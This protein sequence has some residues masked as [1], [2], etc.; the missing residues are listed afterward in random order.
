MTEKVEQLSEEL[1]SFDPTERREALEVLAEMAQQHRIQLP[2][3][4]GA[5]NLHCH[6]FF[7]YNA[8]GYS[9][10]AFAWE[11][12][13]RGLEV[14][15]IVD[16]DCLDG[17]REFLEAGRLLGLKTVS[18]FETRVFIKEYRHL[19][20]NSPKEPGVFYLIGAGF[21][22]P[23]PAGSD[24]ARLLHDMAARAHNRNLDIV[25]RVNAHLDPVRID[26]DRDVLPL[27]AAG[28]ATE[29]HILDAYEHK[30]REH[31]GRDAEALAGFWREKTG[32][33]LARLATLLDDVPALKDVIRARLMKHGGVGYVQPDEG[34]FPALEDVV[35]MT[36]DCGALPSG[37][38]L[39]GANDGEAD[40]LKNFGF[41]RDKGC[42]SITIVP[43]RNWNVDPDERELKVG[44]LN[45]AVAD[46]REL[47]MPIL[48]GTEMNKPGS[49]FVDDFACGALAPHLGEFRRGA[50][51]A[52]AHTL[53][54][55]TA[56]VGYVGEWAEAHF[57]GRVGEKNEFFGRI[58]AARY[59]DAKVMQ[60]CIELGVDAGPDD[61]LKV[62]CS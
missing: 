4:T 32:E 54:K 43:D 1:N 35:R 51:I 28:N 25:R 57:G 31:F 20:T 26:Y 11:A 23:P 60:H 19:V 9:P 42:V 39:D 3:P 58:G 52:W 10:S 8:Y 27:T 37:A 53:L 15:G 13:R 24:G 18:G 45:E 2:A 5:V 55:M 33:T 30:A 34:M 21:V 48:V 49:K 62:L 40:A 14:A 29:R 61:F 56:G 44:K 59:P 22:E 46:A 17:T 41:L 50:H 47:E 7:S 38:W 16:F 12:R 6:T 36:L